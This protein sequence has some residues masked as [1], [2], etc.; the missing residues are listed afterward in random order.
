M[1]EVSAAPLAIPG[2]QAVLRTTE[3]VQASDFSSDGLGSFYRSAYTYTPM[4]DRM[5]IRLEGKPVA[6]RPGKNGNIISEGM[7]PGEIEIT[8]A[9]Q[10]ILP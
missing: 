4:S 3:G 6:F 1:Y 7:L 8:S 10:P 2:Q 9:G 5:G